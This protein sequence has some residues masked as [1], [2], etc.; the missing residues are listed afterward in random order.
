MTWQSKS[1]AEQAGAIVTTLKYLNTLKPFY[2]RYLLQSLSLD[3][4]REVV[5]KALSRVMCNLWG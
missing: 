4:G 2:T 1:E 5:K 3:D